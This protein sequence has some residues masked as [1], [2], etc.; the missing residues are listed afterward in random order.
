VTVVEISYLHPERF[1]T[2]NFRFLQPPLPV[3]EVCE[4]RPAHKR[5]GAIFGKQ[6]AERLVGQML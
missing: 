4:T 5:A 1:P 3:K 2:Q 6:L